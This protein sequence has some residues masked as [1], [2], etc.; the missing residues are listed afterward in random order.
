MPF[1]QRLSKEDRKALRGKILDLAIPAMIANIS[2]TVLTLVD[3]MM[4][5]HLST[6]KLSAVGVASM[7]TWIEFPFAMGI[8]IGT[9]AIVARH[10]GK[11]DYETAKRICDQGIY[12]GFI[13]GLIL[14]IVL[15]IIKDPFLHMLGTTRVTHR[16]AVKYFVVYIS[17]YP[18]LMA[19][20][21]LYGGL[22]GAGDT[23]TPMY[24]TIMSNAVN[25][26]LDY[27][28]I[29]GKFGFPRLGVLG[30]A[31]ATTFSML[32]AFVI[33]LILYDAGKL[34]IGGR[35]SPRLDYSIQKRILKVGIPAMIERL[36]NNALMITYNSMVAHLG[37]IPYAAHYIGIRIESISYMPGLG[38][39]V[40]ATTLVGQNLGRKDVE[41]AEKSAHES[42][43]MGIL[44]MG[45]MGL[46]MIAFPKYL[47]YPFV[48]PMDPH[49]QEVI[50][51]AA[52]YLRI[53]GIS[54]A[55]LAIIFV[56]AGALRG[57]GDTISPVYI[58][59]LNKAIF[60]L[61]P[62]YIMCYIMGIGV[63]GAWIAMSLET[64]T[65]AVSFYLKFRTRSWT[66]IEV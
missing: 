36:V 1:S 21:A 37:E 56:Y 28:L 23:R 64:F 47:A 35:L 39:S 13:T 33:A 5:G 45:L 6:M 49:A 57:A 10:V 58:T 18:A 32:L 3:T 52:W 55:P 27:S 42:A 48:N 19:S 62:T 44:F 30:A 38:F 14:F 66:R 41:M 43:K 24:L 26:F 31:I 60:R 51:L 15:F 9:T 65:S 34:I 40:A 50:N 20:M 46:L 53:V 16:D 4:V 12:M 61:I 2:S 54:E 7:A 22:R 29:F 59:G 8:T 17:S 11:E 63:I 25:I